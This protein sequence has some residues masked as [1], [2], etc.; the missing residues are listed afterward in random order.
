MLRCKRYREVIRGEKLV[1]PSVKHWWSSVN[2]V[3]KKFILCLIP[4]NSLVV[5]S[6]IWYSYLPTSIPRRLSFDAIQRRMNSRI[7]VE[8]QPSRSC[9]LN[10]ALSLLWFSGL[11]VHG[12][13][14]VTV[15]RLTASTATL[16]TAVASTCASTVSRTR[17]TVQQV[18][19]GR[20]VLDT[21]TGLDVPTVIFDYCNGK[22]T[23]QPKPDLIRNPAESVSE[24][25]GHRRR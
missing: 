6:D 20:N 2:S 23:Q 18:C 25:A 12:R 8:S 21:A 3:N 24:S 5:S 17:P 4:R 7:A 11:C 22:I 9:R 13:C 16:S 10:S 15:S 19:R 14:C 1:T